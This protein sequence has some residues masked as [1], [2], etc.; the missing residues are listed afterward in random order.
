MIA[1]SHI[2]EGIIT[3]LLEYN[4]SKMLNMTV[5][6]DDLF[7]NIVSHVEVLNVHIYD[8]SDEMSSIHINRLDVH[9]NIFALLSNKLSISNITIDGMHAKIFTNEKEEL[10]FPQFTSEDEPSE[11]PLKIYV[12]K[13]HL[14]NST[15]S[16]NNRSIPLE[17]SLQN[18]SAE[19]LCNNNEDRYEVTAEFSKAEILYDKKSIILQPFQLSGSVAQEEVVIN[20]LSFA[21]MGIELTGTA[22]ASIG[23]SSTY[24][25][26]EISIDGVPNELIDMFDDNLPVRYRPDISEISAKISFTGTLQDYN[27]VAS[28]T[29]P[30]I[31][32]EE[33]ELTDNK[34][35]VRVLHDTLY[36]DTLS[37]Q[38]FDGKFIAHGFV[39]IDSLQRFSFES[40]LLALDIIPLWDF[41]YTSKAPYTGSFDGSINAEGSVQH[42]LESSISGNISSNNFSYNDKSIPELQTSFTYCKDK[43]E[44][45]LTQGTSKVVV[46][47]SLVD[48][49]LSGHAEIDIREIEYLAGLFDVQ[50]FTGKLI[51]DSDFYGSLNN[52]SVSAQ[53]QGKNILYQGFPVDDVAAQISYKDTS[54]SILS[55]NISGKTKSIKDFTLAML[56]TELDGSCNYN[57]ML[58]GTL[59]DFSGNIQLEADKVLY[60]NR[61]IDHLS[62]KGT[63]ENMHFDLEELSLKIEDLLCK[64]S[65]SFNVLDKS[66][67]AALF[68]EKLDDLDKKSMGKVSAE[69]S[70]EPIIAIDAEL[71]KFNISLAH[72]A[73]DSLPNIQGLVSG[74]VHF[75]GTPDKPHGTLDLKIED[76][77]YEEI[78]FDNVELSA[79]VTPTDIILK[80]AIIGLYQSRLRAKAKVGFV[81]TKARLSISNRS[82]ISGEVTFEDMEAANFAEIF[83]QNIMLKGSLS[84]HATVEGI[85]A[86]PRVSGVLEIQNGFLQ[87][88]DKKLPLTGLQAKI[89]INQDSLEVKEFSCDFNQ[90]K[91]TLTGHILQENF[92][93]FTANLALQVDNFKTLRITGNL[94]KD[95][96]D[97]EIK[98]DDFDLSFLAALIPEIDYS[99]GLVEA[100][101]S[102]NG[103]TSHPS[104][105]GYIH[106][107][108]LEFLPQG[109]IVPFTKGNIDIVF[110]S[111][112]FD[113]HSLTFVYGEGTIS[114][115][116][117]AKYNQSGVQDLYI[118]LSAKDVLFQ[119]KKVLQLT[120]KDAQLQYY[121]NISEFKLNGNI[122][123]GETK[124]LQNVQIAKVVE[125]LGRPKIFRKPTP[126]MAQTKMNI[127][128]TN[129]DDLWVDNNIARIKMKLALNVTGTIANPNLGGR[130][131]LIDGYIIYLDRKFE[132]TRGMLDFIDPNQINP[133]LDIQATAKI[134]N[135][136]QPENPP[137]LITITVI[138]PTDK[139]KINLQ[140]VPA[141]DQANILSILTFGTTREHI[142]SQDPDNY[143]TSLKDILLERA[144][145]YSSQKIAGYVAG[146]L[147]YL[148]GLDDVSIEGNIFNLDD[149]GP[150]LTA[151]KQISDRIKVTY[152]TKVGY[153]NEQSIKLDYKLTDH[154]YLQGQADQE[155]T[156]G[157]DAIYRIHFK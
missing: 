10:L 15:F 125:S 70:L 90:K 80:K 103:K 63:A 3:N 41:L 17:V 35:H 137:Y 64:G 76:P 58:Q 53:L 138:G 105:Q 78:L 12:G 87:T 27:I 24:M 60:E 153:L 91:I 86:Q 21:L 1:G 57:I 51:A 49:I 83:P 126:L 121:K 88:G 73:Q 122:V 14:S 118:N 4:L 37:T 7:T 144:K 75:S 107:K 45:E 141:L 139:A 127:Q 92:E 43:G 34:L 50:G 68:F 131:E 146:R 79:D 5:K 25:N 36:I 29:I 99:K 154:F 94:E 108:K 6:I 72:V 98:V 149:G 119:Q 100:S 2:G 128:I 67:N 74:L 16:Y 19:I 8:S 143:Q 97:G 85:L 61:K 13:V 22:S 124:Y 95:S 93:T 111:G 69:F 48:S 33:I 112:S 18:L 140:S 152:S 123:L 20:E 30:K 104:I 129:S 113:I 62:I 155:G 44:L 71:E 66:G 96:V 56:K 134:K 47:L 52:P 106:G 40:S 11:N 55:S 59:N 114:C 110:D 81:H 89:F 150:Q 130:I 115:D 77:S 136:S 157:I 101:L 116:G 42:I 133:I 117:F 46:R 120:L 31:M 109:F 28:L 135:Y 102:I 145:L 148:L 82:S 142:F 26:G 156:A 65:G 147:T 32:A 132:L 23:G 39:A 38:L 151:S 9:Y 54:L 84:A